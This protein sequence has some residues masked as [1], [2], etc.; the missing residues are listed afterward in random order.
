MSSATIYRLSGS[1]LLVGGL[2]AT[3]GAV[4]QIFLGDAYHNPLWIP[5]AAVIFF[6]TLLI[7]IGL[8]A[9]YAGQIKQAGALG[10]TGF[11]LLFWGFAQFG[12]VF[13]FFDMIILPWFGASADENPPLSFIVYSL[14]AVVFL[15]VGTL[16]LAIVAFRGGG[17]N[18][19]PVVLLL[20]GLVINRVG[21]HVTHLQ[22]VGGILIYLAFAWLG[23]ALLKALPQAA[24]QSSAVAP[25][26][27]VPA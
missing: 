1:A 23:F 15:F 9:V 20:I 3:L 8:P 27:S 18:R 5:V 21:G 7:L 19:G 25:R 17:L 4:A 16:L 24:G 10:M 2:L 13:R 11:L 12:L 6:A 22:D 26:A 14:T